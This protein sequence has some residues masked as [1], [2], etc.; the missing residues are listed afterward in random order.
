MCYWFN[1]KNSNLLLES[2]SLQKYL[3]NTLS[4]FSCNIKIELIYTDN[5]NV[6]DNN[7]IS[8]LIELVDNK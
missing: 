6:V 2:A 7:I 4:L 1:K 5:G 8:Q 3:K